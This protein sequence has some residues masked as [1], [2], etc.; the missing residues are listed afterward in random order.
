[1][2]AA[3]FCGAS[4]LS[5]VLPVPAPAAP[6]PASENWVKSPKNPMLSLGP[7]GA[8]DHQ[9]IFA[10][11]VVKDGGR[12][13]MFYSGGPAGPKTGEDLVR[14]QIGLALSDDGETWTKT[15][16]PLLPLGPRDDFH[17]APSLL[18]NPQ[19]D[20]LKLEGLWHLFYN[21]NRPDDVEHATSRDG[22]QWEKDS[23]SPIF[24][25]AYAPHFVKV[26]AEVRMYYIEKPR[27]ADGKRPP[28]QVSL[29]TGA[30]IYSLRPHPANPMITVSQGWEDRALVYPYV[31]REGSTW[32]M[33]YAAY[34][35]GH[36]TAKTATAIG[37]A[38]S[39]DGVKWTKHASNPVLTP[40]PGSPYDAIYTS[41]QSVIRDG[42][43]YRLYY[44][45]RIDMVHKYF[46][47]GLATKRGNLVDAP[48][49]R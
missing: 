46:S 40:T 48:A 33:F 5:I 39:H 32:V 24:Q 14:Y 25:R 22:L 2:T 20:L 6:A 1:M 7:A 11:A 38:T 42:E 30:D 9:N 29:A 31:L 19:G 43:I 49:A 13:C 12:Y 45:A 4:L 21:G 35:Q 34:W 41:S 27:L 8:F 17:A 44:G 26:G 3:L 47:I 28:W 37:M 16:R 36:P 23:R 15:G 10:P 18:R